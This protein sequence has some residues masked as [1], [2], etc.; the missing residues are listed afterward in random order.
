MMLMSV[1]GRDQMAG[2]TPFLGRGGDLRYKMMLKFSSFNYI[3]IED[4][5]VLPVTLG[6]LK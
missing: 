4:S 3:C 6:L 2:D 1:L 5:E